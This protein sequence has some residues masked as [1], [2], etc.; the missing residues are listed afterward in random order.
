MKYVILIHSNPQPWGHPTSDFLAAHQEQP[1]EERE[2]SNADF[3]TMLTQ[4]SQSG[5]LVGGEA[6]AAPST[7]RLYRWD[8]GR[9]VATDGPYSE[10]KEHLAGFFLIDVASQERAEK[11]VQSFSGPGETVEL[12]PGWTGPT[13]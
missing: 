11:I 2:R 12:R 8:A 7:A 4:L 6:L 9:R 3:E 10:T 5:E 1:A 13:E